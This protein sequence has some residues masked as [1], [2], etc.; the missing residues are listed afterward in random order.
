MLMWWGIAPKFPGGCDSLYKFIKNELIYPE[1]ALNEH[2]EGVVIVCFTITEEGKVEKV[3]L[4]KEFHL[5]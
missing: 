1:K 5:Q 3:Q 4:K 2:L